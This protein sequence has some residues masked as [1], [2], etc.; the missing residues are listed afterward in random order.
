VKVLIS[1]ASGLVGTE[2]AIQLREAGHTPVRL[3]R[4]SP[5]SADEIEWNPATGN[6]PVTGLD[7]IDAVVNLAGATTGRIPWTKRYRKEMVNSR[8]DSTRTLAA[9]I[10][11]SKKKPS[12]FISGSA[13]GF[14]GDRADELLHETSAK[15]DGFLSDLA[16]DWERLALEA[17]TRVVLIRT[18]LVMSPSRGALARLLPLIRLGVGGPIGSGKQWWAWIS[19]RDEAAAI[20]HLIE[21]SGAA[22]PYNLTA[23]EPATCAQVISGLA[24]ELN[25]PS[26]FRIPGWLMTLVFGEAAQ[27]LLLGSQKMSAEK[28]L[29]T[30]FVFQD[31]DL[32]SACRYS[33]GK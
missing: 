17:K 30:G 13:S 24:Q 21:Y 11:R 32:V 3:V 20:R 14:Y 18:T 4:R 23:P 25:R 27:E 2:L 28:L 12:V 31:A 7:G 6:I 29:A 9:A 10:N 5:R 22:G 16:A 8:L 15:G 19:L 33:I 1:G 26:W